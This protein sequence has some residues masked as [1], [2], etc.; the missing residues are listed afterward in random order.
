M[1]QPNN[2]TT[3]HACKEVMERDGGKAVGCCCTGH[4]CKR[5]NP[6]PPELRSQV[7]CVL[8]YC[9]FSHPDYAC[10]YESTRNATRELDLI[11]QLFEQE[12]QRRCDAAKPKKY[13]TAGYSTT[14]GKG[15]IL[16]A[17]NKAIDQY[18]HNL[19]QLSEGGSHARDQV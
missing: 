11:M 18:G 5:D 1:K 13:D 15:P 6:R 19:K 2:H 14:G 7:K 3:H 17:H 8:G 9:E 12:Y 16:H 10:L 4:E